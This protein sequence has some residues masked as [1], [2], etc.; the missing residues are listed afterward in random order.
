MISDI[1]HRRH[2]LHALTRR[3]GPQVS[4]E[5]LAAMLNADEA[6]AASTAAGLTDM[7]QYLESEGDAESSRFLAVLEV[8][9]Q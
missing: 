3:H 1:P 5:A 8:L 9:G 6:R 4:N 2:A 7:R